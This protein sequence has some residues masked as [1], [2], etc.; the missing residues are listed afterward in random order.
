MVLVRNTAAALVFLV[1]FVFSLQ[2]QTVR[3]LETRADGSALLAAHQTSFGKVATPTSAATIS[4]DE[5]IHF[6]RMEGF[7]A[8][9]T[10]SSATL[11][12][13][14]PDE[15][16]NTLM[17]ELF[18]PAGP[19]ALTLLRQ[20]IGASDFSAHGDYSY[21]DSP[22]AKPDTELAH[23]STAMDDAALFPLLR[24]ALHLNPQLRTMILPWSAPAWMKESH[25]MHGGSLNSAYVPLYA[26]Y[27]AKTVEAYAA[28]ALPVYAVALQNEPLNVNASYPTQHMDPAQEVHLAAALQPLLWKHGRDPKLIGYEHNWDTLDYPNKLLSEAAAITGPNSLLFDAISF[29]CYR[30]D[31]SA[32]LAFVKTHPETA[33]WFTECSGTN[34]SSFADDLI[35]QAQHLILGAPLNEAQTVSLWNILLDAHGGP[36]NGGCNDCRALFTV[37]DHDGAKSLHRNVEYYELAHSAP[38]IRPSAVRISA[39][40]DHGLEAVAYQNMD[41]TFALLVL[42]ASPRGMHLDLKWHASA[43]SYDVPARSLLTFTWGQPVP[44]LM[45]GTYRIAASPDASQVLEG[46][47]GS[48]PRLAVPALTPAAV[49]RQLWTVHRLRNGDFAIRNLATAQSLAINSAGKLAAVT[50][51][52]AHLAP[53][54]L[55]LSGNAVC[56]GG[57]Q[58]RG[59]TGASVASDAFRLG[60]LF[61]LIAPPVAQIIDKQ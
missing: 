36:H 15:Q 27:L 13:Q 57:A 34:G 41:S 5:S 49:A 33:V 38:F 31:P 45:D 2:A 26:D 22:D 51:D 43:A 47:G 1:A 4:I 20:P 23:F 48:L 9:L 60:D 3:V 56:L 29:H 50:T 25:T 44:V 55:T 53:L 28:E 59:C 37:E 30:G 32:Q 16:R 18:D 46:N 40:A 58:K 12:A 42:N 19:L 10:D 21:D 14:L 35:W 61:Y 8:S 6:Q 54:T 17:Q 11:L 7:G 52:G 24:Q 39:V